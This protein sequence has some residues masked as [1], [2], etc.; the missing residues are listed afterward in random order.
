MLPDCALGDY[1]N[2]RIRR[3]VRAPMTAH[4]AEGHNRGVSR[5]AARP[6]IGALLACLAL[7]AASLVITAVTG[8]FALAH[9]ALDS[10]IAASD[11]SI[12]LDLIDRL[13]VAPETLIL[14]SSR[15]RQAEPA[16]LQKLTG[17]TG[18]NAAETGGDAADAWVMTRYLADRFPGK[19]RR[20]LWF[21]DVGIAGNTVNPQLAADPRSGKYLG[22][23]E[24]VS[25]P[26]SGSGVS[27]VRGYRPDGS[28][29]QSSIPAVPDHARRLQE[30][31]DKLVAS[32]RENPPVPSS[33]P[34]E[35]RTY[36]ER[37]LGYMN[38]HGARPVIVL[39]PIHPDVLAELERHGFPGRQAALA[40]LGELRS[41]FDFVF[42]DCEDIARWGGSPDDFSNAT[43]VNQRNM[44]R[45][46]VY[47]AA[48]AHP[49]GALR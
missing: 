39:D 34:P 43:H 38:R 27:N 41:R 19:K 49:Q 40:Y 6:W 26:G 8:P 21:V 22:S 20:Y 42:V 9:T 31:V 46:L 7:L 35:P 2:S 10:R 3:S 45:M 24:N 44:R 29:N 37:T 32:I 30:S 25:G 12:K 1:G 16:Y 47:I 11:R 14:G 18:F 23:G 13:K 5:R 28:L 48:A 15:G 33:S 36:F 4:A 17:R